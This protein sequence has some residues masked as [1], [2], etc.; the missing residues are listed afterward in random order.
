MIARLNTR[1]LVVGAAGRGAAASGAMVDPV[2]DIDTPQ[3]LTEAFG[4]SHPTEQ[5]GG[6]DE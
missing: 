2:R 5:R 4:R 1:T 3:D 6:S